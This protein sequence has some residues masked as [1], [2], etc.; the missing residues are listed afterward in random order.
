MPIQKISDF[1]QHMKNNAMLLSAAEGSDGTVDGI[2]EMSVTYVELKPGEQVNPHT[3]NRAEVYV[4]LTGRAMVMTGYEI[5]EV[6]T[7]DVALAPI[8]TPHAIKVMGGE[9]LRFYAFN[10]PPASTCPVVPA[11]EEYLWK[12]KTV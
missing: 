5:T 10:S 7:G 3:H 8:G 9:T 12:W 6:T 1:I 11:P 4:F 2:P